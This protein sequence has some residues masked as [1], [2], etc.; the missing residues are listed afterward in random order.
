MNWEHI[1][2]GYFL[3]NLMLIFVLDL[4][5]TKTEGKMTLTE[6]IVYLFFGFIILLTYPLRK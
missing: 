1:I 4:K 2:S 5:T 6:V 3:I